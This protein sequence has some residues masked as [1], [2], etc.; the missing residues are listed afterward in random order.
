MVNELVIIENNQAVTTSLNV[1]ETFSKEHK[2]INE[3]IKNLTV[4]NSA[5]KNMFYEGEYKNDRGRTYKMYYMNRDGFT[6]LA[7]GFTGKESIRI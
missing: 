5:V 2:H 6:L 3:A 4:E 7:M 1:A